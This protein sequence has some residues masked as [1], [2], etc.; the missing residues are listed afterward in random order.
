MEQKEGSENRKVKA[1][2]F[3]RV[4]RKT[5]PEKIAFGKN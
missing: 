5:P 1:V 2:I 4:V 3:N